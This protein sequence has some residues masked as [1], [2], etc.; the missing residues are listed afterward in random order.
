WQR[1]WVSGDVL[2]SQA[3]YWKATLS[4]A[5]A[6]LE[7]PADRPRPAKQDHAGGYLPL[8]L[9]DEL[10]ASLRALGQRHGTTLF[11]TLMAAWATVLGRL[12]GQRDLVIGTPTAN[13]ARA[14][15]E[16]LI[17][18]FVN[19]LALR[20][21][22]SGEPTVAELLERVRERALEAQQHQD[23]PFEQVVEGVQP[24]RSMAHTPLFQVMLSWE[25]A[26]IGT[27]DLPGLTVDPMDFTTEATAKFDLSLALREAGGRITGGVTYATALFDA[28]TVERYLGYLRRVLAA[29]AADECQPIGRIAL[30]D[31]A[32]RRMLVEEWNATAA[33]Y[34][35]EAC[36]HEL[37]EAQ[38]RRTPGA[39]ALVHAG[40]TLTYAELDARAGRLAHHLRARGVGPDARVA[41]CVERGV[42]MVVGLLAILK[43]GGAYVPLD[44]AYPEER[45]RYMLEDSAPVAVLHDA[46][47]GARFPQL[48]VPAIDLTAPAAWA[49]QPDTAP[50]RGEL[51]AHHLAYI[52]YT[53]GSTGRPKGVMVEHRNA[54]N[55]LCWGR[56]TFGGVMD[57][58]LFSTSL[59]FDLSVFECFVPLVSGGTVHVMRDALELAGAE[60]TLV[61]TVP[62]AMKALVEAGRVPAGVHTVNLAGEPL[63][64]ALVEEIFATTA[65]ERVCNLYGPSET[66][67]YSTWVEMTRGGGFATSVGRPVANTRVYI[68]DAHG[69]PVPAGVAG[70]ILIGGAGVARGYLNRPELTA[71]RFLDD[72]FHGGRMYRTGDLGRWLPDG[73]IEF[74]G[75]ND[76]QVKVRGH[77]IEL[78]EV[79]ARLEEHA[80]VREAVVMAR[81]DVPGDVRLVAYYVGGAGADALRS[82][83]AARLPAYM[84][85]AAYVALEAMPLTPNGKTDRRA[86]P[87]PDGEAF[88]ERGYEAPQGAAEVA[89]AEIW[90]EL[91]GVE[92]VGRHDNFFQLGGHSLMAVRLL[93]RMREAGLHADADTFFTDPTLAALAARAGDAPDDVEIPSNLIP[94]PADPDAAPQSSE[95]FI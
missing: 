55:F 86:L 89:L 65:V 52:I 20:V 7:L 85:P 10:T 29:M 32:E 25:N 34:P 3:D 71:E 83:L 4:G 27:L 76:G 81:E 22:L 8:E 94:K 43:A 18:F 66:T 11:M 80:E 38:A 19:T 26:P 40:E 14:E 87:A 42:E 24:G 36:I 1:G 23:I 92:R 56:D 2:R 74:L 33:E 58:A 9:D 57:R 88:G 60:G 16:G 91:L 17:G 82:H 68:T 61:N 90:S 31:G 46:A 70:E 44:P 49:H 28:A 53:S 39:A 62:S 51:R 13:R 93:D 73:S 47:L 64:R 78:G 41:I 59:N 30:V 63:K 37:F 54:V 50:A 21:D 84:V 12:S 79:E 69:E 72:P 48:P 77:R 15:I 6:L 5:P 75:R 45:L 67:T 95:L 35:A